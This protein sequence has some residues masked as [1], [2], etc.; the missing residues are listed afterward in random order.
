MVL[1]NMADVIKTG[2]IG[3]SSRTGDFGHELHLVES[4]LD[5]SKC[6]FLLSTNIY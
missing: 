6:T 3:G 1:A 4:G 5:I 2:L